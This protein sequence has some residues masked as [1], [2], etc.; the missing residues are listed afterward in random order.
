[1]MGPSFKKNGCSQGL[2]VVPGPLVLEYSRD[3]ASAFL[4]TEDRKASEQ[5]SRNHSFQNSNICS[6]DEVQSKPIT[7]KV[8]KFNI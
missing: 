1:M 4:Y 8:V 2:A 7:A 5:N 3:I 6:I